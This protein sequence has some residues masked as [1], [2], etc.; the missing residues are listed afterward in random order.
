MKH[1]TTLIHKQAFANKIHDLHRSWVRTGDPRK[2]KRFMHYVS[3][4][5]RSFR[6]AGNPDVRSLYGQSH[7]ASAV[8]RLVRQLARGNVR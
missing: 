6:A 2:A 4:Y 8:R 3:A 1:A 7:M 5:T